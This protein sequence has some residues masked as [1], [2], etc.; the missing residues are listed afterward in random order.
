MPIVKYPHIT[1]EH[2]E[3]KMKWLNRI[4][5]RIKCRK[6]NGEWHQYYCTNDCNTCGYNKNRVKMWRK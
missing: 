1:N 4:M 3:G 6:D 2:T 5:A